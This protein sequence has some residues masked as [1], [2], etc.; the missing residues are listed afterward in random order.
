MSIRRNANPEPHCYSNGDAQSYRD[1]NRNCYCHSY[2]NC[3]NNR[4]A[5]TDSVS[6]SRSI[7]KGPSNSAAAALGYSGAPG[8]QQGLLEIF[9]ASK[10]N[11]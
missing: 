7:A 8:K 3:H 5:E 11:T 1:G 4:Y 9:F 10:L 2:G 6:K